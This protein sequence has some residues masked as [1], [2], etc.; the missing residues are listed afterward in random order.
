MNDKIEELLTRGVANIYPNKKALGEV[1]TSDKK[2]KMYQGFDP[3]GIKLHIG[4]LVGLLKLRQWQDLGHEVIFLIGD[5]TGQ[6]GDPSGKTRAREKYLTNEELK[7]NAKDY[8]LQAGKIVRFEGE[9][10]AKILYNGDWLNKLTLVDVLN[11]ADNFTLQQLE[12]R[13][14]YVKR[15]QEGEPVNMREF[16]YP[17]LQA[18]D[19]VA[20]EVDLELGGDDQTFNMLCGRTLS[21]KMLGK[22]KFVMTT[23]LLTDSSGKKIGKT[24]GN[25]IALD[26]DPTEL[27]G[28]IMS[29]PDDVIVNCFELI[30]TVPMSEVESIKE[31]LSDGMN[32]RDAKI[33][34][35][36]EIVTLLH[37]KDDAEKA[38]ENFI[39]TFSRGEIPADIE[40]IKLE[41]GQSTMQLLVSKSIVSSGSE[42]RRLVDS[43]A[44]KKEDGS[45]IDDIN[46][47]PTE[48]TILKIGKKTF[49][50]III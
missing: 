49:V 43:G 46:F 11:I 29:L 30:T 2:L 31:Q 47:T 10:A 3:T 18:Y 13:D 41:E 16:L 33:Q 12:E 48:S 4:H 36:K 19:S 7:E 27:F 15:K 45:K 44:V 22:E 40:E 35:A 5:G 50:K 17:M 1:L 9:N 24:E 23:P 34:L 38:Q 8:V 42:W 26:S 37:T 21:K 14:L 25:V 20:M 32:P 28:M 39:N 6:A